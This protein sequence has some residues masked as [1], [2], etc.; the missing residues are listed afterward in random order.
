MDSGDT[1]EVKVAPLA[2]TLGETE[3]SPE[4][5]IDLEARDVK[6]DDELNDSVIVPET[7]EL[8]RGLALE[9]KVATLLIDRDADDVAEAPPETLAAAEKLVDAVATG[10]AELER[11][12]DDDGVF[13]PDN[14]MVELA[15]EE[16]DLEAD[17]V[18]TAVRDDD[19][20]DDGVSVAS[21]D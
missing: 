15:E 20:E 19:K 7:V 9:E 8:S 6:D 10:D 2:E 4:D 17:V 13:C 21:M 16:R 3:G 18:E 5:E 14:D 1:E 12:A 11:V